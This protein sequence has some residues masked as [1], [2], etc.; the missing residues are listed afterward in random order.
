MTD[1]VVRKRKRHDWPAIR[2]AYVT[3]SPP[4]S[5]RDLARARSIN[6]RSIYQHSA[7]ENWPQIREDYHGAKIA[8]TAELLAVRNAEQTVNSLSIVDETILGLR[9][10]IRAVIDEVASRPLS[11]METERLVSVFPS[12]ATALDKVTRAR[13]LLTGGADSRSQVDLASLILSR[14]VEPPAHVS[15]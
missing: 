1:T 8:A 15:E 3:S 10:T 5:L 12:L 6:L 13:E 2:E 14:S 11:A 7:A 4:V 9:D